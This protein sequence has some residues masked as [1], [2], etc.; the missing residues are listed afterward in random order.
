MCHQLIPTET[1]INTMMGKICIKCD[2]QITRAGYKVK[3]NETT[4]DAKNK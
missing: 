1:M 3:K 4:K 2:I